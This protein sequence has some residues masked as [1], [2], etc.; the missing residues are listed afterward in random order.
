MSKAGEG[1]GTLPLVRRLD[2][3]SGTSSLANFS[4]F[5]EMLREERESARAERE[6]ASVA[7]RAE[8]QAWA[9]E[10]RR[11]MD[12]VVELRVQLALSGKHSKGGAQGSPAVEG[13]STT[14][15]GGANLGAFRMEDLAR[16]LAGIGATRSGV[17]LVDPT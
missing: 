13:R 5:R 9:T 11:L 4:S 10:Q 15:F 17:N 6:A 12:E 1:S 3:G 2:D 7:E 8:R 16:R 14:R